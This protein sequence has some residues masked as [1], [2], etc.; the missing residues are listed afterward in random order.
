VEEEDLSPALD[1]EE[2]LDRAILAL[3]GD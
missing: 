1:P 2:A 3:R